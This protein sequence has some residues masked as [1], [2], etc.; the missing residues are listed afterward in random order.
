MKRNCYE[1]VSI[2]RQIKTKLNTGS[3]PT[4]DLQRAYEGWFTLTSNI[5]CILGSLVN[6]LV[7]DRLFV[8]FSFRILSFFRGSYSYPYKHIRN[9]SLSNSFRV[10]TGHVIVLFSLMPAILYTFMDTDNGKCSSL[11]VRNPELQIFADF[12]R[13]N[14]NSTG[15]WN[16]DVS[17]PNRLLLDD[18]ALLV[19]LFICVHWIDRSRHPGSGGYLFQDSREKTLEAR[20]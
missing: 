14:R 11:T 12:G 18:Y 13:P 15:N 19:Y 5:A 9:Y 20:L 4:T 1:G 7:T 2:V 3:Q 8:I 10:I 6:T 17:R 16:S